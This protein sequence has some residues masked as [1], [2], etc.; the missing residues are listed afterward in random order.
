MAVLPLEDPL[1]A[2][3][4]AGLLVRPLSPLL[5]RELALA[6]RTAE[7]HEAAVDGVLQTLKGFSVITRLA[8]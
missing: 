7:P 2:R 6:H 8:R 4:G 5:M 3:S 1:E